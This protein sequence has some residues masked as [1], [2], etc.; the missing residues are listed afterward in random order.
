M[1]LVEAADTPPF[2]HNN[3][4]ETIEDA[5]EF[6]TTDIFGEFACGPPQ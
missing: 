2:F 3:S 5:V 6:Y 1:S 4:A